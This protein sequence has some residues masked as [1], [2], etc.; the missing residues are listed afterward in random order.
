MAAARGG[1]AGW[2]G[3]WLE[4]VVGDGMG[5][6]AWSRMKRNV[7]DTHHGP[8]DAGTSQESVTVRCNGDSRV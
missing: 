2:R 7:N 3:V 1:R 8:L 5:L 4:K 6:L